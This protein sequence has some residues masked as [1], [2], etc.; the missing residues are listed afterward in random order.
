MASADRRSTPSSITHGSDSSSE[1]TPPCS[2]G[3]RLGQLLSWTEN[4]HY[5]LK[6]MWAEG[7]GIAEIAEKLGKTPSATKKRAHILGLRRRRAKN[8]LEWTAERDEEL[9]A[10]IAAGK[11]GK[12]IGATFGITR[13]AIIGRAHRMGLRL[14]GKVGGSRP[15]SGRKPNPNRVPK[16]RAEKKLRLPKP[17]KVLPTID[18]PLFPFDPPIEN[19]V[20]FLE[21][22]TGQCRWIC[23][24]GQC[25]GAKTFDLTSWCPEHYRVVFL[26]SKKRAA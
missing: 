13:N 23:E 5:R 17:Q 10:L 2:G 6:A 16:R 9:R 11:S 20:P 8:S 14:M 19:R 1:G 22:N 26:P 25:C 4:Q 21:T 12:E 7:E 3:L 24:D 18:G 15:G